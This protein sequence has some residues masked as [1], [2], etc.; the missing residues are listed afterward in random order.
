[1][2]SPRV[3]GLCVVTALTVSAVVAGP[4]SALPP[5][6]G[7][8]VKVPKIEKKYNGAYTD[9]G[10][11]IKSETSS[12]KYEWLPGGVKLG[13]TSTGGKGTLQEVGKYAVGCESE[14]ST[15]EYVGTK[16]AKHVVVTFKG[17]HVPPFICTSPGHAAGELVTKELE[18]R[19]VWKSEVKH[20]ASVDLFPTPE[21]MGEPE[22]KFIAF[23]CGALTVVVRGSVLVPIQANKMSASFKLQFKQKNGFQEVKDYEEGGKLFEDILEA[24]FEEKGWAKSGQTI[25]V[26]V[27]NEESLELNTYV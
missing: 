11:T 25:T 16:E 2:R 5:E 8:C 21:K 13:Q 19:V 3:L 22:P 27:K 12:G 15:G 7:R 9:K 1:M 10:C 23:S 26:T 20:E 6:Y 24:N 17:C 4:A 18:G 14:S